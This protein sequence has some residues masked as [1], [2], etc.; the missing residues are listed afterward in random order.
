MGNNILEDFLVI[1]EKG[2]YCSYG[3]FYLDA[4]LPVTRSVVSHA[5]G[6]H[7]VAGSIDV[8]STSATKSFMEHR[9]GKKAA[10]RFFTYSYENTFKIGDIL[11]TFY[12]AGHILGS[13]LILMEYKSVRYLYTGDYKL[14]DDPTCTTVKLVQADVLI[15][16]STFANPAVAHPDPISEILKLN[17]T[18]HH[19]MLG[20]YALGKA[21]RLTAMINKYC[22]SKKVLVHHSIL[23]FHKIYE[24][25]GCNHWNYFPYNR[26]LMKDVPSDLIYIVPPLTFNSYF[27]AKN[28][29]KVFASGWERLQVNNGITLF[30]SDHVDWQDIIDTVDIVRPRE[31]WTL[32]GDGRALANHYR[33]ELFVKLL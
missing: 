15:T 13:A 24:E 3:D 22:P 8:Y 6:D 31:I 10:Q 23:P 4:K 26:K 9:Y 28:V 12:P 17:E 11:L 20:A 18:H 14:Q 33:D 5:H 19:I 1:N 27:K 29:I 21:Q 7:I 32:H 2:I 30:I 25:H 16:E